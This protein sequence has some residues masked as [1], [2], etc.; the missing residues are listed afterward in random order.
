M[1]VSN[2]SQ[3]R[4]RGFKVRGYNKLTINRWFNYKPKQFITIFDKENN[5]KTEW[6]PRGDSNPRQT[7]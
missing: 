3:E 7:V 1:R 5:L 4:G 6:Y 2:S